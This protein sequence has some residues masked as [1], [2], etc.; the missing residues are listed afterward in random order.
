MATQALRNLASQERSAYREALRFVE[1]DDVCLSHVRMNETA[2]CLLENLVTQLDATSP[3]ESVIQGL[4]ARCINSHEAGFGLA[5]RGWAQPALTLLRDVVETASLAGLFH[6]DKAL[7]AEWLAKPRQQKFRPEAVRDSLRLIEH[8]DKATR[9]IPYQQLSRVAAHPDPESLE[10]LR[11]TGGGAP[12]VGPILHT[13]QFQAVMR[14][15]ARQSVF[16]G[17]AFSTW[18]EE[19]GNAVLRLLFYRA[20]L[21]WLERH[22]GHQ[23]GASLE[24]IDDLLRQA[25]EAVQGLQPS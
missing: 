18:A 12:Q 11:M 2:V 17:M 16:V 21:L 19:R 9:S 1:H 4:A 3:T 5:A 13:D 6:Q 23:V 25:H 14:E 8:I 24:V 10:L 20:S 15:F 7:V 22:M